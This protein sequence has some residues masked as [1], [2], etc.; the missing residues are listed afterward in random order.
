M[1][2]GR[3]RAALPDLQSRLR[4]SAAVEIGRPDEGFLA[5]L[6]ARLLANRQLPVTHGV[7]AWLLTRLQ[8]LDTQNELLTLT[9]RYD[10]ELEQ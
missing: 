5:A 1:A 7:Q 4:A 3:L 9:V 6:L 10:Q 8:Y 2:P